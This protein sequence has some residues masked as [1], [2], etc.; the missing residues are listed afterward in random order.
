MHKKNSFTD[1]PTLFFRTVT[2]NKQL[3]FLGISMK[4]DKLLG[5]LSNHVVANY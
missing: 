4:I 2:G 5:H 1:L 3:I